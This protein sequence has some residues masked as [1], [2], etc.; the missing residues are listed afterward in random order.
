M[1]GKPEKRMLA[2]RIYL[3][4][5]IVCLATYTMMVGLNHGWNLLPIFFADIAAMTWPGQFNFDFTT[6]L[7]LS[8][9]WVAWRNRFSGWG[10]ALGVV[11][12]FAGMLFLAPYLL[13]ASARA[14]GDVKVMLLGESQ[15]RA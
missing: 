15:A 7:A 1:S 12:C 10:I 3:V 11:A 4:V 8:G 13:Y 14:K 5:V 9:L 6:F 2:F